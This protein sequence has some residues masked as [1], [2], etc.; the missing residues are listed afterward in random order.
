MLQID[1]CEDHNFKCP[2]LASGE[3]QMFLI[4]AMLSV[5]LLLQLHENPMASPRDLT[6]D[7]GLHTRPKQWQLNVFLGCG[8]IK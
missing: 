2:L 6:P 7:F 1:L 4:L 3:A 5:F 8:I